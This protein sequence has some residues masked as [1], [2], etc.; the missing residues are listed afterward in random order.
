MEE[1]ADVMETCGAIERGENKASGI[2]CRKLEGTEQAGRCFYTER[3]D[4]GFGP[5]IFHVSFALVDDDGYDNG[6][7]TMGRLLYG[8]SEV[9]AQSS[10]IP[11]VPKVKIGVYAD[12]IDGT[13]RMG[14]MLTDRTVRC[15]LTIRWWAER[16]KVP[17]EEKAETETVDFYISNAPKS[18]RVGQKYQLTCVLPSAGSRI[19][20]EVLTEGGGEITPYGM[21]TAPQTQGIYQIRATLEETQQTA[22]MYLMVR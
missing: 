21:Y 9:F 19:K 7:L 8:D 17:E 2:V 15:R 20:W 16:I 3:I 22:A 4:T 12:P 5:G 6:F 11:G 10:Y 14:V 1:K 18:L 13:F